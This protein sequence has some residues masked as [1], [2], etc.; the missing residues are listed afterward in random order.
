MAEQQSA[1]AVPEAAPAPEAPKGFDDKLSAM[2]GLTEAPSTDAP[3]PEPKEAVEAIPEGEL[4][5]DELSPDE[6]PAGEFEINYQGE[7]RRLSKDEAKK[8]AEMGIDYNA[9]TQS[10]AEERKAVESA[11]AALQAQAQLTPQVLEAAANVKYF[12][13][14]LQRYEKFDWAAHAQQDPLGYVSTRA[15]FDQLQEG[16]RQS[17]S[18][19][20][21][22]NQASEQVKAQISQADI[23]QQFQK[24]LQ[25]AP[26]LRDPER[27]KAEQGRIRSYLQEMGISPDEANSVVD[28]RFLLIARDAMRYRQALKARA[29]RDTKP[30]PTMR[31]GPAP[32]RQSAEVKK[33]ELIRQ[34][35][36]T[37]DPSKRSG[38]MDAVLEAKL[39]RFIP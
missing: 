28:A 25:A 1:P 18:Q 21:Q 17:V 23:Q 2:L 30:A 22:V 5:A 8:F 14:E 9:K 16:Y 34:L 36:S 33:G 26:E 24:V 39:S 10:L 6:A 31:P 29:E 20:Q 38:L 11:K 4:S 15:R 12:Q 13:R 32:V 3:A 35:K 7:T 37:K 19:F 27:L